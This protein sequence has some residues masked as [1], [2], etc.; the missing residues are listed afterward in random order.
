MG[1]RIVQRDS[2]QGWDVAP[3][4]VHLVVGSPPYLGAEHAIEYDGYRYPTAVAGWVGEVAGV[5]RMAWQHLCDGGRLCVNVANT[6]RK[7][8]LDLVSEVG[9]ALRQA[10]FS[11]R[12][13]IVWDKGQKVLGTAWGS[14]ELASAPQLRDQHEYIV[15]AQKGARL[16]VAGYAR[17][18]FEPGEFPTLTVSVWRV[19]PAR[20]DWHPAPY[21]VELAQRLVRLYTQPGM[22][23]VDPWC[24]SGST[25]VAAVQAGC[26]FVGYDLSAAY[27]ERARA[28]VAEA[29]CQFYRPQVEPVVES[30]LALW[31]ASRETG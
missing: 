29:S 12:G 22:V 14:W 8:Y 1:F 19:T 24:G 26:E 21:P 16:D 9:G 18:R 10:G 11:L 27:V 6:G 31:A 30:E 13:H 3:G 17:R 28:R 4:S 2:R 5:A 15:V 25:G 20:C 7:P 23:V